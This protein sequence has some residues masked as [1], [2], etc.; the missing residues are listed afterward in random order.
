MAIR[1]GRHVFNHISRDEL[2]QKTLQTIATVSKLPQIRSGSYEVR[3]L[4]IP[5]ICHVDALWLKNKKRTGT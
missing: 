5:S 2:E 1:A 4:R 3:M